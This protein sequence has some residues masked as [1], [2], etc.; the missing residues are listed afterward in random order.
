MTLRCCAS[1][2]A[3][4]PADAQVIVVD[5]GSRDDTHQ[6][7]VEAFPSIEVV[8]LPANR[9]YSAAVNHGVAVARGE[10]LLL[11]NSDTRVPPSALNAFVAA[12][13]ADA[14]LGIAGAQLM[15]AAGEPQ[16]SAGS[17]PT[18]PW[19]LVMTS[20]AA[21]LLRPF[22]RRA[23]A[24]QAEVEWVSG[25]AMVI[26]RRVWD[27]VGPLREDVRF[28]AQDLDICVRA[29][30]AGWQVRL[31]GAVRIEHLH[32]RTIARDGAALPYVPSLLWPDLLTW[33]RDEYGERWARRARLAMMIA[34]AMRI[35]VRRLLRMDDAVTAAFA[36]GYRALGSLKP[37]A[38]KPRS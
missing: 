30:R 3:A 15:D 1:V 35:G 27:A 13:D 2:V 11:L 17:V 29:R 6:R 38:L 14:M 23:G 4:L 8:R 37:A 20:G 28:Y 21:A 32:G 12:F 9:G 19:L 24:T 18:L 7:I 36:D 22:R 5:D 33:G 31:L 34:A 16:W 26:R 25:A 10:L